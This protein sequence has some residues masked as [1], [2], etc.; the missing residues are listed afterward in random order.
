MVG[1]ILKRG[2]ANAVNVN[3]IMYVRGMRRKRRP[4]KRWIKVLKSDM[5]MSKVGVWRGCK[6]PKSMEGKDLDGKPRIVGG[7]GEMK[8]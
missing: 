6:W 7:E 8:E 4:T 1:H 3:G 5:K 2:E